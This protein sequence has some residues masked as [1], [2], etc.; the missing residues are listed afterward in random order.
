MWFILILYIYDYINTLRVYIF[1]T[2]YTKYEAIRIQI[3]H[4]KPI[5]I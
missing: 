4:R 2:L 3:K 1:E 5:F